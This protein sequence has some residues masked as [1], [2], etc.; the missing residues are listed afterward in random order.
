MKTAYYLK[1]TKK[2]NS[3]LSFSGG[4]P[5]HIPPSKPW[6]PK[7]EKDIQFL[8]QLYIDK[9]MTNSK[10]FYL[11]IYQFKSIGYDPTPFII[12]APENSEINLNININNNNTVAEFGIF[13]EKKQDPD[14]Y[15]PDFNID[16]SSIYLS[17]IFGINPWQEYLLDDQEFFGLISQS[18]AN[19]NFGG[20]S[21]V[22]AIVDNQ[23]KALLF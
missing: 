9:G 13:F 10:P 5:T 18:P 14:E 12:Y 17:K 15:S 6:S 23:Y 21:C 16:D 7:D 8:M 4:Q 2:S 11:Q 1:F 3:D 22:I 20:C 19:F